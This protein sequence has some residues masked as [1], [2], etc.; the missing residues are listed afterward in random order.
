MRFDSSMRRIGELEVVVDPGVPIPLAVQRL[1][2]LTEADVAGAPAPVE[3][4]AQLADFCAGAELVA[5]GAGVR[6]HLLR[7]PG[8]RAP[9][10][11]R[12]VLDT[13]ELARI[14]LPT[15]ESHSLPLLSAALGI[16]HSTGPTA[17]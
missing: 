9:S 2:G 11:R 14:L 12:R 5:H 7:R 16:E 3:G 17:H 4:V 1:C 13:L 15:A 10:A 8:P 6:R